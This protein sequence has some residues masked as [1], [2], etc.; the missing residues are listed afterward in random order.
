MCL[1]TCIQGA[2]FVCSA[3]L[4]V[5]LRFEVDRQDVLRFRLMRTLCTMAGVLS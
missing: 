3:S 1:F 5:E 2:L 4:A